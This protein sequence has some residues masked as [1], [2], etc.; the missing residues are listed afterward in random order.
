MLNETIIFLEI[1]K[2]LAI[3]IAVFY[4]FI[5]F[6]AL[7]RTHNRVLKIYEHLNIEKHEYIKKVFPDA[8]Y[9]DQE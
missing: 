7:K 6:V 1:C 3:F 9:K 2:F 8:K 4:C 5:M